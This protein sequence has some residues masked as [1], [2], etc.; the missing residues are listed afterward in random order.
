MIFMIPIASVDDSWLIIDD[1]YPLLLT[2]INDYWQALMMIMM[3]VVVLVVVVMVLMLVLVL[4]APSSWVWFFSNTDMPQKR[5]LT[6]LEPNLPSVI[7]RKVPVKMDK[8]MTLIRAGFP[9]TT[10]N[11]TENQQELIDHRHERDEPDMKLKHT[12]HPTCRVKTASDHINA[13]QLQEKDLCRSSTQKNSLKRAYKASS[14][15]ASPSFTMSHQESRWLATPMYILVYHGPLQ[16]ATLKGVAP[17]TFTT[18]YQQP[19][20]T[21]WFN[22]TFSS[23]SWRSLNHLKG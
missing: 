19:T 3:L 8:Q 18:V 10:I 13:W 2:T 23:S 17:S 22:V 4:I 9:D 12:S 7:R 1:D 21:R 15:S 5:P 11:H 20:T 6:Y 16:I 14:E